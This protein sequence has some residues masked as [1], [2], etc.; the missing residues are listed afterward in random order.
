MG[1]LTFNLGPRAIQFPQCDE[2]SFNLSVLV[3]QNGRG[4]FLR[5]TL[6]AHIGADLAELDITKLGS[7]LAP[8]FCQDARFDIGAL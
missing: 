8:K 3:D 7:Q 2:L 1:E 5:V 4:V 6:N